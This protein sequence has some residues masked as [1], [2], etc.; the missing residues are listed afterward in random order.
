MKLQVAF[1]IVLLAAVSI[2]LLGG[3]NS[4]RA[5]AADEQPTPPPMAAPV[6]DPAALDEATR[7]VKKLLKD[8]IEAAKTPPAKLDLAKSFL[9]KGI[10]TQGDPAELYVLFRMA[11]ESAAGLADASLAVQAIDEM[12]RWFQIDPLAMKLETLS[13]IAK[14]T[15]PPAQQKAFADT[16]L[17]VADDAAAADSYDLAK[18]VIALGVPAAR[19]ARDADLVKQLQN[20]DKEANA[21]KPAFAEVKAAQATLDEHPL[22]AD[23]NL[24]VGRYRAFMKADWDHG[25]PM[26]ALGSDL[27]LKQL[28]TAE[29]EAD[30]ELDATKRPDEQ[31]KLADAWWNYASAVESSTRDRVES[32]ALIWYAKALPQLSGLQKLRVEKLLQEVSGRLFAK[33][34]NALRAKKVSRDRGAGSNHGSAFVDVLDEGGLLIGLEVGTVDVA[35]QRFI[36]SVRPLYRSPRGET[37]G[38]LHGAGGPGNIVTL[39]AKEGFAVGG[40][41]AKVS[42][43]LEG[44]SVTFM[45]LQGLTMTPRNA[46]TSPWVGGQTSGGE[47]RLGGSGSPVIG[48]AGR[49]TNVVE[50]IS[51]ITLR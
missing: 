13:S 16:A 27:K 40:I 15:M 37:S 32:R 48:I 42:G 38:M 8:D 11:R 36:R 18:Q 49:V 47:I 50:A 19:K 26:L 5:V 31:L 21:L 20:R 4:G 1:V 35:G 12:A 2:A 6:P 14:M 30:A 44:L 25:A 28:A 33:I 41:T 34:Q 43:R 7:A 17:I 45:Q 23:A 39:K 22:D 24:A 10:D 29:L 51:L 3:L 46:Y 9:Q